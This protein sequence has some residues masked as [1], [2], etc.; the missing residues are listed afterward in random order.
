MSS[1]SQLKVLMQTQQESLHIKNI[2]AAAVT[3]T[4]SR[5]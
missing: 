2:F 3:D 4:S 5:L 1:S